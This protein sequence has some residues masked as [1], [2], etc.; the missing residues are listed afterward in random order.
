[1]NIFPLKIILPLLTPSQNVYDRMHFIEQW[2]LGISYQWELKAVGADDDKFRVKWE[3][4][5]KVTF[6]SYRSR[7]MDKGN[8][9]GGMKQLLDALE[10]LGLIFFDSPAFLEDGYFQFIGKPQRT[11]IIIEKIQKGGDKR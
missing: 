6:V 1:M 10:K 7:L 2:R 3:E 9:I 11:E 4:K 5:R 8:L